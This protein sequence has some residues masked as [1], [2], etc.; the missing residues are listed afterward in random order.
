MFHIKTYNKISEKGLTRFARDKYEVA[1]EM[2]SPDAYVLRSHKLH[3]EDIPGSLL[4]VA[5]AGAGVNNL[6]VAEYTKRGIVAFNTP[7][8][9]A[10]A[11]KEL[12]LA[13]MLLSS[14]DIL[15]GKDF[16]ATLTDMDDAGE[17][18]K[19]LEAE[20]KRF[21]GNELKGKTLGVVGLG[22]IGSM[23]AEMA[24]AMGMDVAGYDPAL[25]VDAAWRLPSQVERKESLNALLASADYVSLHVPAIEATHHL[26]NAETLALM[27]PDAVVVNFAREAIVDAHAVVEALDA[28][29]LRQY[30]CDFPEPC[31]IGRRDVIA[32]PHIGASTAEAEENCAMMAA[33]Q[34]RDFLE[35]GNIKNSVNFPAIAMARLPGSTRLTFSNENV[36]GVLGHVLSI[37]ADYDVNV[38]DMMNK[39]RNDVAYNILDLAKAPAAEVIAAIEAVEHVIRVRVVPA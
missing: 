12:V 15:G 32:L 34:V 29:A 30:V 27:K 31:L 11:V 10:N 4:A 16:V 25:S 38:N 7:G 24:L 20:K 22:A 26:I 2:A 3:N 36:S 9:N 5:R 35:N 14:R 37:F 18:A 19:L 33:D 23:V 28:G 1:A 39:S 13:A 21:A 8:A 6:P 17:M